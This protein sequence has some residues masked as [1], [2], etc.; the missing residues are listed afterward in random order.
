VADSGFGFDKFGMCCGHW[1]ACGGLSL[2]T[3]CGP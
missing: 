2:P 1:A 3:R